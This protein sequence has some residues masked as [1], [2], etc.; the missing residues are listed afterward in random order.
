MF[1]FTPVYEQPTG[2][3]V[4]TISALKKGVN[5]FLCAATSNTERVRYLASL[6]PCYLDDPIGYINA[7]TLSGSQPAW[8]AGR[9]TLYPTA[10]P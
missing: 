10:A 3:A 1:E 2:S 7:F 5:V 9:I 6:K 4:A 8:P